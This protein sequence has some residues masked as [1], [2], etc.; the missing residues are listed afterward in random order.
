MHTAH[1]QMLTHLPLEL[2]SSIVAFCA[3]S[4]VRAMRLVAPSL[5]DLIHREKRLRVS[6]GKALRKAQAETFD[7]RC[8]DSM[9]APYAPGPGGWRGGVVQHAAACGITS[10]VAVVQW[11]VMRVV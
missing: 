6:F 5:A 10:L 7:W 4:T 11:Q 9:A 1:S 2:Q 8:F 3:P